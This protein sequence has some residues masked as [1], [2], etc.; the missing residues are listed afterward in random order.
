MQR[1]LLMALLLI[2]PLAH[3]GELV[4]GTILGRN[5]FGLSM[6]VKQDPLRV[7]TRTLVYEEEP[8][9]SHLEVPPNR[10]AFS[11]FNH[12]IG[13]VYL[14]RVDSVTGKIL[15]TESI[16]VSSSGGISA[17]KSNFLTAWNTLMFS[18]ATTV[19]AADPESFIEDFKPYFKNNADLVNPYHY[20]YVSELIVLDVN[21]QSKLIKHYA[22]G[23]VSA[24]SI[25]MMPDGRTLFML[26]GGSSGRL[27]MFVSE[28]SQSL[29]KGELFSIGQ[30]AGGFVRESIGKASALRMKLRLKKVSFE[31]IFER[32]IP[33]ADSCPEDFNSVRSHHGF[34]CL[35]LEK[36]Y[37]KEAAIFE[38]ARVSAMLG[39]SSP[40]LLAHTLSFDADSNVLIARAPDGQ[41]TQFK[42][43]RD[44]KLQS[45]YANLELK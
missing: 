8:A 37:R 23:R 24:T 20:G 30:K 40:Q 4:P 9:T 6:D 44:E 32:I 15:D 39:I 14:S 1:S 43:S 41:T 21:A 34:E 38:P 27:Y 42:L 12:T 26:D 17:P 45:D 10:Y 29:A 7:G 25:L 13:S 18:E 36:K 3:A 31:K 33:D 11:L 35:K 2:V 28:K 5:I 16:D 19:D 22:A